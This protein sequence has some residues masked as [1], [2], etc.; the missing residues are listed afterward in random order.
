[1]KKVILSTMLALS[2]M[3][4]SAQAMMG[5]GGGYDS[6]HMGDSY[7]GNHMVDGYGGNSM[8]N[9]YGGNQYMARGGGWSNQERTRFYDETADLRRQLNSKRLDYENARR[10]P[11]TSSDNLFQIERE[12]R[13]I[14][15]QIDGRSPQVRVGR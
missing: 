4:T 3:A 12:L 10:N 9:S 5:G 15:Y 11:N 14:M 2:V 8:E 1:M 7:G 13:D 6:N